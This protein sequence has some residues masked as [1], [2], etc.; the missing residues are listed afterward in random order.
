MNRWGK[1][2]QTPLGAVSAPRVAGLGWLD[3]ENA[4]VAVLTALAVLCTALV[5][6]K[7]LT[8]TQ[9]TR[10]GVLCPYLNTPHLPNRFE[11]VA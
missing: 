7:P 5:L 2:G 3:A 9:N 6:S 1:T 11:T 8:K 10:G 4:P